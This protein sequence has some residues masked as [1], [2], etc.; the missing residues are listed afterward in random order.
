MD[1]T[2]VIAIADMVI[3]LVD[4]LAEATSLYNRAKSGEIISDQE[5]LDGQAKVKAAVKA[6][7]DAV[8]G[9]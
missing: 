1:P 2:Q 7:D 8:A 5:I 4:K 3:T 6:W 9:G